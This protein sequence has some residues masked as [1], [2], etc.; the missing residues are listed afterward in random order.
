MWQLRGLWCSGVDEQSEHLT[1]RSLSTDGFWQGEVVLDAV[2]IAT[3]VLVFNDVAGF[4]QVGDDAEGGALGDAERSGDVAQANPRIMRDADQ[5]AGMVGEEAPL[6]HGT[7]ID[8]FFLNRT[9]SFAKLVSCWF[10]RLA[11]RVWRVHAYS[12]CCCNR[13]V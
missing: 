4:G 8:R 9:A 7:S 2:A 10:N 1:D 11:V 6:G 12:Y 13:A 3:A 5:G